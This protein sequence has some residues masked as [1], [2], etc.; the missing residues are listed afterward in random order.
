MVRAVGKIPIRKAAQAF[1]R[2]GK[3]LGVVTDLTRL[4]AEAN[5]SK[6]EHGG[7]GAFLQ[8]RSKSLGRRG[9]ARGGRALATHEGGSVPRRRPLGGQPGAAR[10][11]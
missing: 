4:C 2:S 3:D 5:T 9:T 11:P 8:D 10:K 6:L 7:R 1:V